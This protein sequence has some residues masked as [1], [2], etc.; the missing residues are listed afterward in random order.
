MKTKNFLLILFFLLTSLFLQGCTVLE[1]INKQISYHFEQ[2]NNPSQK[3]RKYMLTEESSIIFGQLTDRHNLYANQ[4]LVV[5]AFSN[6]FSKDEIVSSSYHRQNNSHFGLYLPLGN[7]RIAVFADIDNNGKYQK[8]ELIGKS[9]LHLSR[10]SYKSNKTK[11]INISLQ[12]VSTSQQNIN[13]PVPPIKITTASVFFPPGTIRSLND[14][15][16]SDHT[17]ELGMYE[18]GAFLEK[19]PGM[20]YAEEEDFFHKIPVVFVHGIGGSAQVFQ[21]MSNKLNKKYYKPLYFHYP[22]GADLNQMA[23]LF[24]SIFLSGELYKAPSSPMI[25]VAHSMGGI[26][27]REALNYYQAHA[28]ENSVK[29]FISMATP[30]G[31]HPSVPGKESKVAEYLLPAW[32]NLNTNSQFIKKLFRKPLPQSLSHKLI[33]FYQNNS[34][35]NINT[36][37]DGVIPVYSQ[38]RNPVQQQATT[39]HGF[40]KTHA[41]GVSDKSVINSVMKSISAVRNDLPETHYR[42]IQKGGFNIN[43]NNGYSEKEKYAI[44]NYGTYLQAIFLN[45]IKSTVPET[46]NLQQIIQGKINATSYLQ[47]A[48]KKFY[49]D[50]PKLAKKINTK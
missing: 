18:P 34:K 17:A 41:K 37:S 42:Y 14:D 4:N 45:K 10:K 16:F 19:T 26:V 25:I 43:L 33:F 30:F 22:S 6:R 49:R 47:S 31:G 36:S 2:S 3:N 8:H 32:K 12:S 15:I 39:I 7:Y 29:L 40:N 13:L 27:V 11:K 9:T 38:L 48:W 24:Y 1:N 50:Y 20:L 35:I 5:V 28:K 46:D 21:K 23:E 44:R